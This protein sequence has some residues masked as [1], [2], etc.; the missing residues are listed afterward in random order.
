LVKCVYCVCYA[1]TRVLDLLGEEVRNESGIEGGERGTENADLVD[2]NEE[3][4]V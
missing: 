4:E 2:V 3:F 1:D